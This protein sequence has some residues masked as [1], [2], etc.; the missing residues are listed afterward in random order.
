MRFRSNKSEFIKKNYNDLKVLNPG[1]PIYIR[2]ADGVQPHV[3][4]RYGK[5]LSLKIKEKL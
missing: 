2:P 1:L 4:A 3:A 5:F